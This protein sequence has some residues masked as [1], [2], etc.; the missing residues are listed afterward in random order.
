MTNLEYVRMKLKAFEISEAELIDAGIDP[1]AE[2]AP[3]SAVVGK[4][5]ISIIEERI[6][7][8]YRT[9]I[10]EQGFSV[11][12]DMR[13]IAKYYLYLC[14]RWGVTPDAEVQ[15]LSGLSVITDVSSMW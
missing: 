11:S 5:I 15:R 4:G 10:S 2:Y 13:D 3:G 8:P 1:Q 6:F 9:N 14:R 12:W 7:A